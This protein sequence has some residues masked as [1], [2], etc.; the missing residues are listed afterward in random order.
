MR[1]RLG[2]K[3]EIGEQLGSHSSRAGDDEKGGGKWLGPERILEIKQAGL[4]G[5]LDVGRDGKIGAKD[6]C[7]VVFASTTGQLVLSTELEDT[8][9]E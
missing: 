7:Q 5:G 2:S 3:S 6:S 9:E 4:S 8:G 1:K